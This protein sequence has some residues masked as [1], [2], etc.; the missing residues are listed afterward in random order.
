VSPTVIA[1]VTGDPTM[2]KPPSQCFIEQP[3]L[4]SRPCAM[5]LAATIEAAARELG[6]EHA[7]VWLYT[8]DPT[9]LACL[10]MYSRAL[11][12]HTSAMQLPARQFDRYAAALGGACDDAN[13]EAAPI[14]LD[15]RRLGVL[16][17]ER[18]ASAAGFSADE[19]A[20]A[21]TLAGRLAAIL[22]AAARRT[23]PPLS[24]VTAPLVA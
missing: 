6:C 18:A 13:V 23:A 14:V 19:R 1:P 24:L 8:G 4:A 9:T 16:C 10:D 20:D 5:A 11:D 12:R 21:G 2:Y 15:G 7:S 17:L 3:G 22:D